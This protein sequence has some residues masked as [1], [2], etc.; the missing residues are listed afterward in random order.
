MIHC[1]SNCKLNASSTLGVRIWYNAFSQEVVTTSR[2][3]KHKC[4]RG[5]RYMQ[6]PLSMLRSFI[7]SKASP[8]FLDP[9]S[10]VRLRRW[11]GPWPFLIPIDIMQPI[12]SHR[13]RIRLPIIFLE[14]PLLRAGYTS[15]C[16]SAEETSD[17]AVRFVDSFVLA[18]T[19]TWGCPVH[20]CVQFFW[21]GYCVFALSRRR[22]LIYDAQTVCAELHRCARKTE[23]V[24]L[25]LRQCWRW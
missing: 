16:Y 2:K 22:Y 4:R 21:I 9:R 24:I 14:E 23:C 7:T 3:R 20:G 12:P 18:S 13:P 25:S 6:T 15:W 10:R 5:Y 8:P 17:A 11:A 1:C 19:R